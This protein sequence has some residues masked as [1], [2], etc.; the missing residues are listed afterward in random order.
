MTPTTPVRFL[1][2]SDLHLG[3]PFNGVPGDSGMKLREVRLESVSRIDAVARERGVDFVVVAG[4]VFDAN[5]VDDRV[6]HQSCARFSAFS[7]PVFVIPGNHDHAF[8]P[9]TVFRR[10]AFRSACP[11]N[12][13][14]SLEATPQ[15]VLDRPVVI[16][17]A[18]LV[19]RHH[20]G[21]VTSHI[22]ADFGRDMAPD[23]VRIGLAHGS[24]VGFDADED[25][26]PTNFIDPERA[27]KGDLDYLALGDW[28][29]LVEV[30]PRTWYSGAPEPTN[31]RSAMP[32]RVVIVEITSR[33]AVPVVTH[34]PVARNAMGEASRHP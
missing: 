24:V 30:N 28:H 22:D 8:G 13:H 2:T 5:T 29:G 18:P 17:P 14:V 11:P 21:D 15:V 9:D 34:V 1:H 25:R 26:D 33:G 32:G 20:A 12:L 27:R 7:V 19:H 31:F 6:I 3:R 23:A 10:P 4:D 16:L